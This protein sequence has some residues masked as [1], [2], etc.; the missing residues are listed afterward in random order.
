MGL[1]DILNGMQNG[2]RGQREPAPPGGGSGGMS[3]WMMALLGM[4]AYKAIKGGGLG[5]MLGGQ[6]GG[7]GRPRQPPD[8]S[9]I[10][11]DSGNRSVDGLCHRLMHRSQ[12]YALKR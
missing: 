2:P 6:S 8:W 7:G 3:P 10:R 9:A 12:K 4:L 5:N 1:L 11:F